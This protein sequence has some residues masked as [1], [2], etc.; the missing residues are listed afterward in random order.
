MA[1]PI[2]KVRLQNT[3]YNVEILTGDMD[4]ITQQIQSKQES[5]MMLQTQLLRENRDLNL[6][7]QELFTL[8][9]QTTGT[10]PPS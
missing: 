6:L 7:Q 3:L 5:I 1:P 2:Q 10:F 9:I 4:S 8:Y